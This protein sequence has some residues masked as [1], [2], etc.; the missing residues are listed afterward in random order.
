MGWSAAASGS[1][2]SLIGGLV[3]ASGGDEEAAPT[4][5]TTAVPTTTTTSIVTTTTEPPTG[6]VAPLT[7]LRVADAAGGPPGAG[8]QG[9]QPRRSGET[10]VPQLGLL[11]A[12]VVFEEIVEGNITRLVGIFHSQQ[13]GRVGPVR[14]ART[15]DVQLLPQFGRILLGWS[16][17]NAGVVGAVRSNPALIDAGVDVATGSYSRQGPHPAPHNLYVEADQLWG[18]APEG[19]P[20]PPALF[21][22]RSPG[23]ELPPEARQA[24]GVDLSW[25]GGAVTAPVSWRWDEN[26]RVWVRSQRGRFHVDQG[27]QAIT[28][29]NVVV[30]VTEYGRSAADTRSPEAQTVGSGELFAYVNGRVIHGRWDRPDVAKPATLVDDAGQPVLLSPGQTWVELPRSGG[31]TTVFRP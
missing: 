7:G 12:D 15:T 10:A 9:R 28:A 17:G 1:S 24:L 22:Y 31:V 18:T 5:T 8:G 23:Q 30:L 4:T 16:G 29:K 20:P 27:G 11:K 21:Q 25:G 3:L 19:T 13:P 2:P 6:P 26:L 14:S